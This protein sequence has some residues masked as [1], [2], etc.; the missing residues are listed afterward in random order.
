MDW[1]LTYKKTAINIGAL[2]CCISLALGAWAPPKAEAFNFGNAA[3]VLIGSAIQYDHFNKQLNY[4]DNQG[5]DEY[6]EQIASQEGVNDDPELN[7]MLGRIMNR[8][9]ASIAKNDPSIQEKPYHYFVNSKTTFN[10]FCTLGHNLSVNTGLFTLL[11][12]NEDEIAVVVGHEMG[13]GQKG[14]PIKGYQKSV[15]LDLITKLYKSQNSSGAQQMAANVIANYATANGVTKPQEWEAD[16]LAFDY[17][18]EAGYNPG[19]GAATWQRVIEA[20]GKSKSNF[21]GEIFSPSDHPKNEE[22]RDN[23]AKKLY[24]YSKKNVSA[25]RGTIKIKNKLFLTTTANSAMSGEERS[26][27]VAGNLA[28]VYRNNETIPDAY[29]ENGVVK[30]G[31]QDIMIPNPDEPSAGEIAKLLNEIK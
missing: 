24:E 9:S 23:Y 8:L 15:P 17:T 18:V 7:A 1:K 26:Y 20:M 2:G 12:N 3:G 27:L 4:F 21:V 10:A 5:R 30:M 6:Y 22:R 13:H 28:A 29:V 31:V 25:D 19:A 14:H 16:N 11:N